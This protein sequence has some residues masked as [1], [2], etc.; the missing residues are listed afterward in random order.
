MSERKQFFIALA[1][2]GAMALLSTIAGVIVLATRPGADPTATHPA[3][4]ANSSKWTITAGRSMRTGLMKP[5][6][7]DDALA[8]S[9]ASM[10]T[11]HAKGR[12]HVEGRTVHY[13]AWED[14]SPQ[15]WDVPHGH[16]IVVSKA[17]DTEVIHPSP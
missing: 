9:I 1:I 2:V 3:S 6:E 10:E 16:T 14:G 8:E 11:R 5:R 13:F 7:H 15:T 12:P 17:P 4:P